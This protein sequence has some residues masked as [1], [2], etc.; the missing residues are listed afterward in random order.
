MADALGS[1]EDTLG[2]K[3][4]PFP[5][6]GWGV[7]IGGVAIAFMWFNR[8][9]GDTAATDATT[10]TTGDAAAGLDT[11]MLSAQDVMNAQDGE[12]FTGNDSGDNSD[13]APV[14][15]NYYGT[16]TP[17]NPTGSPTG[18]ITTNALWLA[19]GVAFL[20]GKG[21]GAIGSQNALSKYLGHKPISVAE[22]GLVN[23]VIAHQGQPPSWSVGTT[24]TVKHPTPHG[25]TSAQTKTKTVTIHKG[26][27]IRSV[28]RKHWGS[29]THAH[30]EAFRR[31]NGM[32]T[33]AKLHVGQHVKVK[34]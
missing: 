25:G 13:P 32:G 30:I 31:M 33:N 27:T 17:T 28:V 29:A 26:D 24:T 5:V 6:W 34:A 19:K 1:I 15:N 3:V 23:Q 18:G 9:S 2:D 21:H 12:L 22:E 16:A 10:D 11:D 20:T 14:V 7:A 8:G 4:G